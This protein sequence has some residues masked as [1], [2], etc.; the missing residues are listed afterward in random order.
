MKELRL[1]Y[2]FILFFLRLVSYSQNHDSLWS[3]YNNKSLSDTDRIKAIHIIA[4]SYT[5]NNPDTAILLANLELELANSIPSKKGKMLSAGAYNTMGVAFELKGNYPKSLEFFLKA[6]K[7][8]EETGNKKGVGACY[9]SIGIVY[10][11][12]SDYAKALEYGLKNLKIAEELN[13]KKGIARCYSNIGLIYSEQNS[14]LKALDY[15]LKSLKLA[16][17]INDK[18]S[19]ESCYSNIGIIY[20]EQFKYPEALTYYLSALQ[21][22]KEI[23]DQQG[24]G[25]CY[26]NLS[27]LY[28]KLTNYKQA[29]CYGD[30]ALQITK[31]TD[32][33]DNASLAYENL[34]TAYSKIGKYKEAYENH[35][36][37]KILID[38]IFNADN[39]KQLGDMKT[40]FEVEKKEAEL[41]IKSVAEQE[42]LKA[43]SSEEKK[44]QQVI[45]AS[46]VGVL[47]VVM[48]FSLFLYKRFRIT[49]R[50]KN[51]I[52][53]QK[54]KV[55][56][57]YAMLHEKN[58]EVMD[59]IYYARRI[60]RVLITSEKYIENSLNRLIKK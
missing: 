3:V 41:K 53:K 16:K 39:S 34:A 51:I 45:I 24:V 37:F 30:S 43:V 6:L 31:Q 25:T 14:I 54:Q 9:G 19:I 32:D 55:D 11:N 33:I 20:V 59:S 46:V 40:K 18:S 58:K 15:Y 36:K 42:K 27:D 26:V 35:V 2:V 60:Q 23:D 13:D 4:W 44:R 10:K 49:N 22:S 29:I 12:Q 47:M 38:S 56:E 8:C 48:V 17:E 52:E 57:A 28:N 21:L 7:V 5:N 1:L 50:Q